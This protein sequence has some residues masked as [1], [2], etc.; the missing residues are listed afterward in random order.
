MGEDVGWGLS[1]INP[2][3]I[4]TMQYALTV[5]NRGKT[6]RTERYYVTHDGTIT[7]PATAV[8]VEA[9][10]EVLHHENAFEQALHR[11]PGAS[12]HEPRRTYRTVRKAYQT[13]KE[14]PFQ[15]GEPYVV[16]NSA[17]GMFNLEHPVTKECAWFSERET[18]A[19]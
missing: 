13:A 4:T 14:A 17:P 9:W 7:R 5:L 10:L 12:R 18:I 8:E 3:H 1:H 16:I 19:L 11:T 6:S 15:V 2:Q